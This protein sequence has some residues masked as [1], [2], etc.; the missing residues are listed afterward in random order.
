MF[1]GSL[2][3]SCWVDLRRDETSRREE[4][5]LTPVR[6]C[7][8]EEVIRKGG[9]LS[10]KAESLRGPGIQEWVEKPV[11]TAKLRES[12]APGMTPLEGF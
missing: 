6:R 10:G 11:A 3:F 12:V 1:P 5:A 4:A 9:K 2:P 7:L 8:S